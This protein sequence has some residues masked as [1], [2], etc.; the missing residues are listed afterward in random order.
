MDTANC[1][2]GQLSRRVAQAIELGS[3]FGGVR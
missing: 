3:S 2:D 1:P